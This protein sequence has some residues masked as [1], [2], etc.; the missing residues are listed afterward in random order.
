MR[1]LVGKFIGPYE[2]IQFLEQRNQSSQYIA[3]DQNEQKKV[4]IRFYFPGESFSEKQRKLILSAF[5]RLRRIEHPSL[6]NILD[7]NM[8]GRIPYLV[9]PYTAAES[10]Q[11]RLTGAIPWRVAVRLL[12]PITHAVELAHRHHIQHGN[13]NAHNILWTENGLMLSDL[14]HEH[15]LGLMN[16]TPEVAHSPSNDFHRDI[17][18]LAEV[19]YAMVCGSDFE[20]PLNIENLP[21]QVRQVISKAVSNDPKLAFA[22]MSEFARELEALVGTKPSQSTTS[23]RH[24]VTPGPALRSS[25]S[26][27]RKSLPLAWLL[28]PIMLI[29]FI[30][31][32]VLTKP[33]GFL[34]PRSDAS[35]QDQNLAAG[36]NPENEDLLPA[37]M[38]TQT[39]MPAEPIGND[40][41]PA[42]QPPATTSPGTTPEPS[43]EIGSSIISP[44]DGMR[45]L[46]VPAG[47]F[48]MG[49]DDRDANEQPQH[50][51]YLD[52]FWIDETEI[53]NGMYAECVV[54][55]ACTPPIT[56]AS[57]TRDAYF[58]NPDYDT[59]PVIFVSWSQ[60]QDYCTWAGR[61]LPSEAEWEKAARGVD[62][63]ICPWGNQSPDNSLLNYNMNFSDTKPSGS[64]P[65][66]SSPY[67]ALDMAGNVWEWVSDWYDSQYYQDAPTDNPTGPES[68]SRHVLRGGSWYYDLNYI[69]A[70]FRFSANDSTTLNDV[71]FRCALKP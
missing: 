9:M 65:A 4:V 8:A 51:V 3:F 26:R 33:F 11:Q 7:Y 20:K 56:N 50:S 46:Y 45:L 42:L 68:G 1:T 59:Y 25:Q 60:A 49:S 48:L 13:I 38:N 35:Q 34:Q 66:G 15:L 23:R 40:S 44:V 28:F 64:F 17:R 19:L 37:V 47:E 67:A 61:R 31:V 21:A 14:G 18:M 63:R 43:F 29:A 53:T 27:K 69:R 6:V 58:G 22:S 57:S 39:D 71:G 36:I 54:S 10:L 24:V 55:G 5:D 52:A 16:N 32:L 2:I 62:G 12:A 41:Q 30:F 70:A